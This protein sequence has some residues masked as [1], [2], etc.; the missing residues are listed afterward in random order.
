MTSMGALVGCTLGGFAPAL[1]G[2]S[3]LS[4]GAVLLGVVGGIAGVWL[5]AHVSSH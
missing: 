3:E 5:G 4:L 1:W 2:G